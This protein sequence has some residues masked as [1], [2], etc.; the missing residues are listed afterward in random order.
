M[1]VLCPA[2]CFEVGAHLLKEERIA[3]T[4]DK[5]LCSRDYCIENVFI[6]D[7]FHEVLGPSFMVS[8]L[9]SAEEYRTELFSCVEIKVNQIV[10]VSNY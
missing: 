1:D 2:V 5:R 4:E 7:A 6:A 3:G 9:T 8:G 10:Y